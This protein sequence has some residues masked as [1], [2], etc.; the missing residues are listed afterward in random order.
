MK[1]FFIELGWR[2]GSAL[3]L[4]IHF[5]S[6]LRHSWLY[7]VTPR[8]TDRQFS[9]LSQFYCTCS[10]RIIFCPG[11]KDSVLAFVFVQ[12]SLIDRCVRY[13]DN[14]KRHFSS[15]LEISLK[16]TSR[17]PYPSSAGEFDMKEF[18]LLRIFAKSFLYIIF[19]IL[20]VLAGP[21]GQ[22]SKQKWK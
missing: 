21:K 22:P 9:Q 15:V 14:Y 12:W 10:K 20:S 11:W 18:H 16:W 7:P 4:L 19:L 5:I 1:S 2:L 6:F 3:F 13:W 17:H 8:F